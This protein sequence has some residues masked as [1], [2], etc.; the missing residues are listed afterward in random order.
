MATPQDQILVIEL[1]GTNLRAARFDPASCRLLGRRQRLVPASS[2]GETPSAVHD[3]V[4]ATVFE[5]GG[6][7][8]RGAVPATVSVAY[9]GPVD[10]SGVALAAP[11]LARSPSRPVAVRAA[12]ERMWP[13]SRVVVLND[14]SAAGYR[15]VHHGYRDFCILTVGSG[16]GHKVFLDGRPQVGEGSRGGEIGHLAVGFLPD[17][18]RC[19][20][21]GKGH[22]GAIASGRG[23]VEMVRAWAARDPAGLS[24]SVLAALEPSAIRAE[25]V[26]AAF[27]DG[28]EAVREIVR[29][30]ARVL[31]IGLAA[32]HVSVGVE[33]FVVIGGFAFSLGEEYRRVLVEMSRESC[34]DLGQDWDQMIEL[35]FPDD[36]HGLIGAGLFAS[37]TVQ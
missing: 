30:A 18:P 2:P 33:R 5:L 19:D 22:V 4:F 21:G 34:W 36:D 24:S 3:R 8:L 15:Y 32:I 25:A 20:C 9:P 37:G 27:R 23:T 6:D 13:G 14:L 11:T 28:D 10:P 12:V 1:G 16:V 26:A 31:A 35:G 7:V 29:R 17:A